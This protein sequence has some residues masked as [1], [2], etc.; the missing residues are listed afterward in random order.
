VIIIRYKI[1]RKN[2]ELEEK[3]LY[4]H[5]LNIILNKKRFKKIFIIFMHI[6][7]EYLTWIFQ[8]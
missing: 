4:I 2:E 6:T 8:Y 1:Y 3:A 5:I 7:H